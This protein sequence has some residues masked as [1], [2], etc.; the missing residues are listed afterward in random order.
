MDGSQILLSPICNDLGDNQKHI[1]L[2]K[3]KY[4]WKSCQLFTYGTVDIKIPCLNNSS[5]PYQHK[6]LSKFPGSGTRFLTKM[7]SIQLS[8]EIESSNT[9][10]G[11]KENKPTFSG[12]L[13]R[14]NC[15]HSVCCVSPTSP[16]MG[17]YFMLDVQTIQVHI[18]AISAV[19][20]NHMFL[21]SSC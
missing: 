5:P 3:E 4:I 15:E 8:M 10:K 9:N 13:P 19:L 12:S 1:C 7:F 17:C 14:N 18:I 11:M 21:T 2:L 16:C 20:M 6:V